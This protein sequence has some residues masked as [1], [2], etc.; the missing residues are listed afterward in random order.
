M[1]PFSQR[2]EPFAKRLQADQAHPLFIKNVQAAYEHLCQGETGLLPE[3]QIQ[4]P[5]PQP[6][7]ETLPLSTQQDGKDALPH[8]IQIRLNGGLGTSMGL[9]QA[10][11]LLSVKQDLCFLDIIAQQSEALRIP[12]LLM[13]SYATQEDSLQ[14]LQR[15]PK[16]RQIH[17]KLP[18]DFLQ[19]RIPKIRQDD[20]SPAQHTDDDLTWCPPGHG[21]IYL[22]LITSGL[23]DALLQADIRYAFV[24]NADNLGASVDLSILGYFAKN[25]FPFLMEVAD[26]TSVDRKG[27][28]LAIHR[29]GHLLL[30]ESAQ[31]PPEDEDAFQD[32]QRYRYFNTN[33]IWL[34]LRHLQQT[35]QDNG[36]ILGLP[37]IRNAKTVDPRDP[38]STPVY[39]LET[40]MGTAISIFPNA[41]ALRVP[42]SRF[43]PVKTT[44]DL[45]AVRSD[46]YTLDPLGRIALHPQRKGIPPTVSLDPRFYKLVDDLDQ[47]F[48]H[49]PPSL[50]HCTSLSLQG[51]ITFGHNVTCR[52]H[53]A[54]S[55]STP[56]IVPDHAQLTG[57]LSLPPAQAIPTLPPASPHRYQAYYCEE[58]IWQLASEPTFANVE[59]YAVFVSNPDKACALWHQ[60]ACTTPW[61]PVLWDYHVIYLAAT[62][63][64]SSPW[65]I[66][67]LDTLL[68]MPI[69]LADYLTQT[70]AMLD[71][72]H[73]SYAPSFRLFP[74]DI[75]LRDFYSDRSHMLDKHRTWRQP[76]PPWPAIMPN[77][78][79]PLHL[80]R[81]IDLQDPTL[82]PSLDLTQFRERFLP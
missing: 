16:I 53:V 71:E 47:R 28:H 42:R 55:A 66:W 56:Q 13:N 52:G 26:R 18:L 25:D 78:P 69:P 36:G 15:H 58:N 9:Q 74:R 61:E 23:L 73:P 62:G 50:L 59:G 70:F 54:L 4:P 33:N 12:L 22:A 48:P 39:Q 77:R 40:A 41:Q 81:I 7:A 10:K 34:N 14:R 32:I 29:D 30:R 31:C 79:T 76:P 5:P 44:Q 27:G 51:D 38:T 37:L 65:Q 43:A 3:S 21:D 60:R 49:D 82:G 2:F 46:A 68:G 45:L 17:P 64:P 11:S 8:T 1:H 67:D 63:S 75:F 19:H 6:D 57:S 20:L 24:A 80:L 35:L 72:I